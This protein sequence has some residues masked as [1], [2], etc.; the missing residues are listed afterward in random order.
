MVQNM[1]APFTKAT[2]NDEQCVNT[3]G[4]LII[5]R[6]VYLLVKVIKI[7]NRIFLLPMII[8]I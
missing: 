3:E 4:K 7:L 8:Q 5:Y 1:I 6:C 2:K